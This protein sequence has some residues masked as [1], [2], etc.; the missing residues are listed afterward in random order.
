MNHQITLEEIAPMNPY[1]EAYCKAHGHN[2]QHKFDSMEYML[3][4]HDRHVKFRKDTD[5]MEMPGNKHY[6]AAFI[7]WLEEVGNV[8][9]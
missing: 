8:A 9:D 6:Q 4:I 5:W 1:Y 3:W 7:K 2:P